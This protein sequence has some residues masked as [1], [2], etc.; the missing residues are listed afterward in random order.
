MAAMA[1]LVITVYLARGKAP[2]A[3]TGIPLVF[4]IIMTGWAM[5]YNLQNFMSKGN[6]MLFVIGVIVLA[7]EVWMIFETLVVMKKVV[8]TKAETL[9]EC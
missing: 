7:L 6:T 3:V 9:E 5:L 4:M 1:L 2:A 8:G